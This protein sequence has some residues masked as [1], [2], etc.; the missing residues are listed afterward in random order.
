MS[1]L[2][3]FWNLIT[4]VGLPMLSG[5]GLIAAAALV[6]FKVGG[7]L[8]HM[9][10]AGLIAGA[11]A[12]LAR[13]DGYASARADCQ[14]SILRGRVAQLESDK[15]ALQSRMEVSIRIEESA[16]AQARA[17]R[18]NIAQLTEKADG[19]AS[20]LEK[21]PVAVACGW[22]E[23]ERRRLLAIKPDPSGR[24]GANTTPR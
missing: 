18:Q 21:K 13:A 15:A 24:G 19:L 2:W 7:Q 11:V 8:G 23:S 17:D 1:G 22:S 16:A 9:I 20:E 3:G 14:D 12:L 10:G 5:V 4:G 6:W